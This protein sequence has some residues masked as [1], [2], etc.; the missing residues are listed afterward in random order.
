[1]ARRK[2]E[3]LSDLVTVEAIGGKYAWLDRPFR[4]FSAVLGRVVE[5]P[6]G[7][8]F[9]RESIPLLRGSCPRGGGGHDYLSRTDS[10]PVVSKQRAADVYYELQA[11]SD[12]LRGYGHAK[13]AWRAVLRG[14]K[15]LV[16]RVWPGYFHR[17]PVAATLSEISGRK[18]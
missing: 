17:H 5:I 3:Y 11:L 4:F 14:V 6:A 1:M 16:V 12:S 9:D 10:V 7:F 8:V 13:L 18:A 15:T 2:A